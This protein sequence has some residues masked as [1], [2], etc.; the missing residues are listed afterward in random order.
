M[1]ESGTVVIEMPPAEG[2]VLARIWRSITG[3]G[4]ALLLGL[5]I[6]ACFFGVLVYAVIHLFWVV[7]VRWKRRRRRRTARSGQV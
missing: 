7:K 1:S 6:F 4:Q 3:V 5:G 2:G